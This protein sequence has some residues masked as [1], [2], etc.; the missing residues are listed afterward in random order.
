LKGRGL[1]H[2]QTDEK[3]HQNGFVKGHDFSHAS[4]INRVNWALALALLHLL[5]LNV[6]GNLWR[7][8][9]QTTRRP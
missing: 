2:A 5:R 9:S 6:V 8:F 1:S 3:H 7:S 4:K